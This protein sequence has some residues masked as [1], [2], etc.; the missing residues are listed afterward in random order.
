[1]KARRMVG[2]ALRG[3][4]RNRLRTFFMMVGIMVG[5][6]VFTVVASAGMGARERIMDRVRVIL[7]KA[8]SGAY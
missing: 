5:I 1:M 6:T 2:Q 8:S 3:L 7:I 4:N